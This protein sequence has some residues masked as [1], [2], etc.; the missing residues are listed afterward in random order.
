MSMCSKDK[1]MSSL[2][3]FEDVCLQYISFTISIF[4]SM[5]LIHLLSE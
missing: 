1:V 5:Y 4:V 2:F 3:C